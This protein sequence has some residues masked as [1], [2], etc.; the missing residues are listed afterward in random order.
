MKISCI[1]IHHQL[2][3][4]AWKPFF[5]TTL[6]CRLH[7]M[8]PICRAVII[9]LN[10]ISRILSQRHEF[11]LGFAYYDFVFYRSWRWIYL[12]VVS[13][14]SPD[15]VHR[16]MQGASIITG[17][18]RSRGRAR[19]ILADNARPTTSLQVST[20]CTV[21]IY[22][23]GINVF[24]YQSFMM[25]NHVCNNTKWNFDWSNWFW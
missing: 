6:A 2:N 12:H 21:C 20:I 3:L 1:T 18:P 25:K 9:F 5:L 11:G 13:R 15:W 19:G 24:L 14:N 7:L 16:I 22:L 23:F 8:P 17:S 4:W 10:I